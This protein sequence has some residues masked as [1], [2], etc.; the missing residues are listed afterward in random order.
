MI[1]AMCIVQFTGLFFIQT[2]HIL[3]V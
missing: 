1:L 3:F 2:L